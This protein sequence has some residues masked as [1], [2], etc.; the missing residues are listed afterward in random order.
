MN[1][2][3]E[4][5]K[6]DDCL[7]KLTP[8][9]LRMILSDME[10]LSNALGRIKEPPRGLFPAFYLGLSYTTEKAFYDKICEIRKKYGIEQQ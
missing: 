8:S 4:F 2:D 5:A 7:S 9:D 10:Y 6:S 3:M 1:I